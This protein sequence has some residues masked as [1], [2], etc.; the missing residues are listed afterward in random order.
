MCVI[1]AVAVNDFAKNEV[2]VSRVLA[3]RGLP[4]RWVDPGWHDLPS[5]AVGG[6][7]ADANAAGMRIPS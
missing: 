7:A 1:M 4:L 6:D 2:F 3:A 5:F